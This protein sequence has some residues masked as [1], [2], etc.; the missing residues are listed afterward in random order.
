M[1]RIVVC[2]ALAGSLLLAG[3]APASAAPRGM[4]WLGDLLS[5]LLSRFLD[6]PVPTGAGDLFAKNGCEIDPSGRPICPAVAG[7]P[8]APLRG[9]TAGPFAKNGCDLDP[10]GRP[11]CSAT[12]GEDP[13]HPAGQGLRLADRTR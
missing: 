10:S 11:I 6:V 8:S 1:R 5:G 4:D 9:G 13:G 2:V 7:E 12:A 3:A